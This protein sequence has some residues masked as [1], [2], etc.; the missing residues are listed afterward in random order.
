LKGGIVPGT[1]SFAAGRFAFQLDG[2]LC[3][4]LNAVN[5][6]DI[7]AEVITEPAGPA[8]FAKKHIG[9]P[10]YEEFEV[11]L[12]FA[13]AKELYEWIKASWN[14]SYARKNGAIVGTDLKLTPVSEVQFTN[15]LI[16]ETTIPALDA[17]SKDPAYLTVKFSPEYTRATKPTEKVAKLVADKQK[18][19]TAANF[20]LEIDGLDCSKVSKVDAF[21]IRQAAVTD[22]IGD[23]RDYVKE[24]GKVEF[25]NLKITFAEASAQTWEAWFEDF[26]IKGNNGDK[27]EKEGALVLLTADRKTELARITLHNLGIFALRRGQAAN[28]EAVQKVTAELYCERMELKVGA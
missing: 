15:A 8:G 13:M 27:N 10:K 9:Q 7:S 21:T 3:G 22:D 26:V 20:R 19:F 6:G 2:V 28:N 12:G 11:Q 1:R 24:P 16:T 5:G 18:A 17:S 25:P 23:A 4:F 14:Q